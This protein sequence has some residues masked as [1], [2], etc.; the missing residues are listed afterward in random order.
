MFLTA[1]G[2]PAIGNVEIS[3]S[4]H[5]TCVCGEWVSLELSNMILYEDKYP[6]NALGD[7]LSVKVIF[8]W[9]GVHLFFMING[10]IIYLTILAKRGATDFLVAR[11]SRLLPPYWSAVNYHRPCRWLSKA[12]TTTPDN[13]IRRCLS[14][15]AIVCLLF[16][17]LVAGGRTS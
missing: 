8:G 4:C 12:L 7:A 5:I 15:G 10:F 9:I 11:L 16:Q 13:V 14:R 6:V 17:Y 1:P 3:I 2:W